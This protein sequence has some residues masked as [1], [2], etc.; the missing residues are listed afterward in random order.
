K[1]GKFLFGRAAGDEQQPGVLLPGRAARFAAAAGGAGRFGGR[2]AGAAFGRLRRGLPGAVFSRLPGRRSRFGAV[3][4]AAA[5]A[6]AGSAL[7]RGRG[8]LAGLGLRRGGF[9][10][11]LRAAALAAARTAAATAG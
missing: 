11:V 9:A 7:P 5:A 3:A 6:G 1:A 4:A 2:G 10:V 8:A